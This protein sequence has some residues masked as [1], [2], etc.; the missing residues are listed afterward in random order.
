MPRAASIDRPINRRDAALLVDYY[1][2]HAEDRIGPAYRRECDFMDWVTEHTR[3]AIDP[4]CVLP[5]RDRT[6]LLWG[7][8][9]AQS[10]SLGIRESLPSGASL[11]QITTSTA[12][13]QSSSFDLPV[14]ER[15]CEKANLFA[16]ES[17]ERLRPPPRHHRPERGH[18]HD[19]LARPPPPASSHWAPGS[20]IVVGPFPAVAAE[21]AQ[22]L[23]RTITAVITPS[24]SPP[25]SPPASSRS[26]A[27]RR[28]GWPPFPM[29]RSCRCSIDC[30]ATSPARR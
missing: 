18:T 9:F 30:V 26:I 21:P 22:G 28:P 12:P 19:G 1:D 10:L 11:A 3:D 16:M 2:R 5:G 15:R 17:I 29:S 23:R 14:R 24:T 13:G 25:G 7:D 27:R 20:V 6:V 8:S 4:S